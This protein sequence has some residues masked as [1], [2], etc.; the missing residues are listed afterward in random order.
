MTRTRGSL[1]VVVT[2]ATILSAAATPA[3]AQTLGQIL[4][5]ANAITVPIVSTGTG[6][7]FAGTFTLQRFVAT[8]TGVN[9]VGLLT[10]IVTPTGGVPT[11]IVQ[12]VVVPVTATQVPTAAATCPI[13]HLD[14]GPLALDLLGLQVNLSQVVLDIVAQSG[15]GNLLGNLLCSVTGLLDSPGGLARLLNQILGILG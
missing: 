10:G 1:L 8:A 11:A 13:L 3:R 2:F 4:A 7:A 5:G 9:A 12:N 14:L 6:A 15:A